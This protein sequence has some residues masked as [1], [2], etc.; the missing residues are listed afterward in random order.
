[1]G[2]GENTLAVERRE[3]WDG[4]RTYDGDPITEETLVAFSLK[5]GAEYDENGNFVCYA[6]N[7]TK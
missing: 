5:C 6:G 3:E 7:D 2:G 1:M 4:K